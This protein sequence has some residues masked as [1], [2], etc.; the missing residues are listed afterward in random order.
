MEGCRERR[1][2]WRQQRPCF[3]PPRAKARSYCRMTPSTT[4]Y[5]HV[6]DILDT[7]GASESPYQTPHHTLLA[8]KAYNHLYQ[9]HEAITSRSRA[10]SAARCSVLL[11]SKPLASAVPRTSSLSNCN[12]LLQTT[13]SI[14]Q[15]STATCLSCESREQRTTNT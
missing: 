8:T 11:T 3:V 15:T 10:S 12:K 6:V 5:M 2:L 4:A 7:G 14:S 9:T 13:K 1:T